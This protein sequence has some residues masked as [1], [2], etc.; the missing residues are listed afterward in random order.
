MALTH[1]KRASTAFQRAKA[2]T[3]QL[4]DSKWTRSVEAVIGALLGVWRW[5]E[6]PETWFWL[7]RLMVTLVVGTLG[8]LTAYAALFLFNWAV[9]RWL[10]EPEAKGLIPVDRPP[11]NPSGVIVS[12]ER[13]AIEPLRAYDPLTGGL[14]GDF[15]TCRFTVQ[16]VMVVTREK[17][18]L[19]KMRLGVTLKPASAGV[20]YVTLDLY[21]RIYQQSAIPIRDEDVLRFDANEHQ[22]F[23]LIA[24][25]AQWPGENWIERIDRHGCKLIVHDCQDF[26][27]FKALAIP[28][29]GEL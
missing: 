5:N 27:H 7:W 23:E 21:R 26:V 25:T 8:A 14:T 20:E 29:Q 28:G 16:G 12:V 10:Q 2:V 6:T 24:Q 3:K 1:S 13:V 4:Q 9:A 15:Q 19:L 11:I 17:P 22:A 18:R